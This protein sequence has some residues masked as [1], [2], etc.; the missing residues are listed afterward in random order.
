[1]S[2]ARWVRAC[3]GTA[4]VVLSLAACGSSP[5]ATGGLVNVSDAGA[6]ASVDL[7]FAAFADATLSEPIV[8][9]ANVSASGVR[10]YILAFMTGAG[11]KCAPAW[12]SGEAYQAIAA[13]A[14]MG[15][16]RSAGG[17]FAVSFGGAYAETTGMMDANCTTPEDLAKVYVAIID[18]YWP[19]GA[20]GTPWFDFD[21]E[22]GESNKKVVNDRRIEA[23]I[24][25]RSGS[26]DTSSRKYSK[27]L[28][29]GY[30]LAANPDLGVADAGAI[31]MKGLADSGLVVD[32]FN[33]MAME[34]GSWYYGKQKDEGYG[35][36]GK[37]AEM[38]ATKMQ[39]QIIDFYAKATRSVVID[40]AKAWSMVR[41]TPNIGENNGTFAEGENH[42]IF[43]LQNAQAL[44]EFA[45][46]LASKGTP[47]AGLSEWS[48]SRDRPCPTKPAQSVLEPFS[49]LR[50]APPSASCTSVSTQPWEFSKVLMGANAPA[51]QP[52][53]VS[54]SPTPSTVPGAPTKV[55]ATAGNTNASVSWTGSTSGGGSVIS[56]YTVTSSPGGL[57]ATTTGATTAT[58]TGLTNGTAYTF[59][60]TATNATG[61]SLPS[62]ASAEVSPSVSP[63]VSPS[64]TSSVS[65]S[66]SEYDA[67]ATYK[68][69]DLVVYKG[70]T[71]RANWVANDGQCPVQADCAAK[72]A[73]DLHGFAPGLWTLAR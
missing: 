19:A 29:I 48:L 41:I 3:A 69:G 49:G 8:T 63:T 70:Q 42:G 72:D 5:S 10:T 67:A 44:R 47:M 57:T 65:P 52:T 64:P 71:Y 1:M 30:T 56:G 23:L 17:S 38:V 51:P 14:A 59:T 66:A 37:L 39:K 18:K 26:L 33:G 11:G 36:M 24:L 6:P 45:S 55:S 53:T 35:N 16:I 25:I 34:Y 28:R 32:E 54:P 2:V 62:G 22:G 21:I 9:V 31:V 50:W 12:G 46:G 61:T 20:S 27:E 43:T 15:V 58:V 73:T 68:K 7:G 4:V 60:V 13:E 40:D